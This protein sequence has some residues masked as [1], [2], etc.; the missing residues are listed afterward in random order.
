MKIIKATIDN[1][2]EITQQALSVGLMQSNCVI[3]LVLGENEI[4]NISTLFPG[5]V[6]L[7]VSKLL[8]ER[9]ISMSRKEREDNL[10]SELKFIALNSTNTCHMQ[11]IQFLF[12]EELNIDPIKL[13]Q[14]ISRKRPIVAI[15]PGGLDNNN[16]FYATPGH[17]EYINYQLSELQD[18]QVIS[19]CEHGVT[20]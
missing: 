10:A 18:V 14:Q 16:L 20:K 8:A 7:N 5:E 13:L 12:A 17:A 4:K 9:L 15:W 1:L 6:F 11:R 3:F 2:K 19:T